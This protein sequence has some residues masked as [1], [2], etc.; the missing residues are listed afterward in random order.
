MFQLNRSKILTKIQDTYQQRLNNQ[1]VNG[2]PMATAEPDQSSPSSS[3]VYSS[4]VEIDINVADPGPSLAKTDPET[5][6]CL[7]C[8]QFSV[9]T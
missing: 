7:V 1:D 5:V 6:V 4:I 2:Q 9:C 8:Y 3:F